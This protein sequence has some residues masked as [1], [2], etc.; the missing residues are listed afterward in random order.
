MDLGK[1]SVNDQFLIT[2]GVVINEPELLFK[3]IEDSE[4][5]YQI[6]KL[7]NNN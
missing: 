5:N 3:R 1:N 4:I 7:K 2:K 6:D